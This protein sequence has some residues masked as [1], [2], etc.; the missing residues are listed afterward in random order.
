[1]VKVLFAVGPFL[2]GLM[3]YNRGTKFLS[4]FTLKYKL[5]PMEYHPFLI[6]HDPLKYALGVIRLS[7]ALK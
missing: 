1:M 7:V 5:V 3:G 4:L 2:V 6:T